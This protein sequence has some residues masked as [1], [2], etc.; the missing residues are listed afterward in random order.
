MDVYL[1]DIVVHS[2]A[3]KEHIEHVKLIIDILRRERLFLSQNKLHFL[4]NSLEVLGW[5]ITDNGI[6]MTNGP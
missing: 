4:K 2:D 1:D 3:L 5:L 6:Q